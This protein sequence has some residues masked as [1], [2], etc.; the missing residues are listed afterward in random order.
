MATQSTGNN[1][2]RIFVCVGPG[3]VGKTT[4]A[5]SLAMAA[6]FQGYRALVITIDPARRLATSMGLDNLDHTVQTISPALCQQ[7]SDSISNQQTIGSLHATMLDQEHAL[8][9]VILKHAKD[10]ASAKRVLDN[11]IYRSIAASLSG[12]HE[13]AALTRLHEL[14]HSEKYDIIV[15]DTPPASHAIEFLDAPRKL[16]DAIDSK[17]IDWF[18]NMDTTRGKKRIR[19]SAIGRTGSYILEKLSQFIGTKFLKDLAGFFHAINDVLGDFRSKAEEILSLLQSGDAGFVAITS[20]DD[21]AITEAIA[22]RGQLADRNH[23]F[24]TFVVNRYIEQ[25]RP[26]TVQ[27]TTPVTKEDISLFAKDHLDSAHEELLHEIVSSYPILAERDSQ[28]VQRL[29]NTGDT[30]Y[31]LAMQPTDVHDLSA[32][33]LMA[34]VHLQ[35]KIFPE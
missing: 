26:V 27:V 22:L 1:S 14:Y 17:A 2:K 11:A 3:G 5:A 24:T 25:P 29:R 33:S 21:N 10:P 30:V 8:D 23:G 15:V 31:T 19:W 32:L 16:I 12:T 35:N 4:T 18:R 9:S 28:A 20:T 34:K 6:C 7:L 13:Y